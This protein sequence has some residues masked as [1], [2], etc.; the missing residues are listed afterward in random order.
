MGSSKKAVTENPSAPTKW[1]RRGV[2]SRRH[3]LILLFLTAVDVHLAGVAY[4]QA[5]MEFT[6]ATAASSPCYI[7]AGADGS[8]W[9]TVYFGNEITE[10]AIP[11]PGSNPIGLASWPDG[12]HWFREQSGTLA[13]LEEEPRPSI[14]EV[15]RDRRPRVVVFRSGP[16]TSQTVTGTTRALTPTSCSSDSHDFSAGEGPVTVTLLQSTD[17][18]TLGVQVCAG[19]IDNNDCTINLQRIAV[20]QTVTGYRKGGR[21]QNLKFLPPNCG[22]GGPAP[23]GPVQ[24][25]AI[26][27]YPN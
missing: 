10:F 18:L 9:L 7:V 24:Y 23:P 27:S 8:L 11:A 4:A 14:D 12:S 6:F 21:S 13:Q 5:I 22:G 16:R 15:P 19:G 25:T 2:W 26:V 1:N 17:N 20:N 3:R